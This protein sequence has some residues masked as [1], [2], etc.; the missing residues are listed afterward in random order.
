M[1]TPRALRLSSLATF[2]ARVSVRSTSRTLDRRPMYHI[3][4]PSSLASSTR[5]SWLSP[6]RKSFFTLFATSPASPTR[7]KAR[8]ISSS[9]LPVSACGYMA[10]VTVQSWYSFRVMVGAEVSV[11]FSARL[12][13]VRLHSK[14]VYWVTIAFTY[15]NTLAPMAMAKMQQRAHTLLLPQA[16]L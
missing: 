9:T 16:C 10:V 7:P 12:L 4:S 6:S 15:Y 13:M 8:Y 5:R 3:T 2:F 1:I 11:V 14:I